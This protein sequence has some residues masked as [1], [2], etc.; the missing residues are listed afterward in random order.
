MP[1]LIGIDGLAAGT[2]FAL[3]A[4]IVTLGRDPESDIALMDQ[5]VSPR[6][7]RLVTSEAGQVR[8]QDEGSAGGVFVNDARVSQ[9]VLAPGDLLQIG[10]SVFRFEA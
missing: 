6:P 2:M 8:V 9:A 4:P 7:A 3:S 1:H 5:A 10:D